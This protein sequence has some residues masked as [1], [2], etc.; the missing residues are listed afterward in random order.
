MA[1]DGTFHPIAQRPSEERAY[2]TLPYYRSD[3]GNIQLLIS[4]YSVNTMLNTIIDLDL[5]SYNTSITYAELSILISDFDRVF[6]EVEDIIVNIKATPRSSE[7][8]P[9]I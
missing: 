2:N 8:S 3:M 9:N 1:I 7:Y 6:G 4:E 5:L